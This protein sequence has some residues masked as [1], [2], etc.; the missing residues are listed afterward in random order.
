MFKNNPALER[1]TAK[2]LESTYLRETTLKMSREKL[3]NF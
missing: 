3:Y 2:G 1:F